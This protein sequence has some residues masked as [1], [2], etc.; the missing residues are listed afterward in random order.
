[1]FCVIYDFTVEVSQQD[2]FKQ[3]WHQ[4]TLRIRS[5]SESLGSRLHKVID[6]EVT[7][8][9]YAQWPDREH[10]ESHAETL[11][12]ELIRKEQ[13]ECI[14]SGPTVVFALTVTDDLL[15]V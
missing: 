13:A 15:R 12:V 5:E 4:L 3:L 8:I 1:M 2:K 10:W 14:E 11:G 7:W 6:D 9:A